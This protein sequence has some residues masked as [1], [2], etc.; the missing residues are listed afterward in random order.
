MGQEAEEALPY[1]QPDKPP[2]N[3]RPTFRCMIRR[4]FRRPFP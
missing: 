2:Q 4:R 3:W 1:I